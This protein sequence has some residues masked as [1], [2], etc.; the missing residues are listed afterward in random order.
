MGELHLEVIK[1][2]LL[3]DFNLVVKVHKPRVNYR[4]TV[5]RAVELTGQCHRQIGGQQLFARLDFRLE[6][7]ADREARM[8]M[9]RLPAG[10]HSGG[11]AGGG[12]GRVPC[13]PW[14]GAASWVAFP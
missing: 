7:T 9:S 14:R 10:G 12:H 5:E 4:E 11:P 13:A 1:H 2:R 6:P 3:R 8:V